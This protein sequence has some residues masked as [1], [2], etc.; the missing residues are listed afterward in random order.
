MSA[1]SYMY[2]TL[3]ACWTFLQ[4]LCASQSQ[5]RLKITPSGLAWR[6]DGGGKS[7]EVPQSGV[8]GLA[9]R[10]AVHCDWERLSAASK[11]RPSHSHII[12]RS[13]RHR[14]SL[15]DS[16]CA[17]PAAD[18][19]GLYWSKTAQ[20]CQLSVQRSQER[21]VQLTGFREK[22]R[23]RQAGPERMSLIR[24]A[25]VLPSYPSKQCPY[26]CCYAQDLA[27]LREAIALLGHSIEVRWAS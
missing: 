26:S 21:L 17:R 8:P 2:C 12:A 10:K 22:A 25:L 11:R 9:I 24:V 20:G 7:V 6:R 5:G 3:R 14:V 1:D 16:T 27:S 4:V 15:A 13:C 19:Q 18:I 23:P